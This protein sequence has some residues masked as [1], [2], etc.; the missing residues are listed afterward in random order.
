MDERSFYKDVEL[1][2]QEKEDALH[3]A[4]KKKWFNLRHEAYWKSQEG[5]KEMKRLKVVAKQFGLI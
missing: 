4:R 2:D 1:T 3:E 5:Q